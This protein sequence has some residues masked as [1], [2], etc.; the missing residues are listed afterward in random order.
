MISTQESFD[1]MTQP[2]ATKQQSC[3]ATIED[4]FKGDWG[5]FPQQAIFADT[6]NG[7]I[8]ENEGTCTGF[9]CLPLCDGRFFG[10]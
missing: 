6:A 1:F 8:S 3:A 4:G 10:I 2:M 7:R 9:P 5:C